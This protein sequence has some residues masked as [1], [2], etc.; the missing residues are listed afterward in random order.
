CRADAPGRPR[1]VLVWEEQAPRPWPL[2]GRHRWQRARD[3]AL[4]DEALI[5]E[6]EVVRVVLVI[7]DEDG[8]V[9]PQVRAA[10][11]HRRRAVEEHG[12]RRH[13]GEDW[14]SCDFYGQ[15]QALNWGVVKND[16]RVVE[17]RG[18]RG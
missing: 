7:P 11:G 12:G 14:R 18:Q 13:G 9:A 3:D 15:R 6:R 8:H 17:P 5:D 16:L 1:S 10:D 2:A 4:R